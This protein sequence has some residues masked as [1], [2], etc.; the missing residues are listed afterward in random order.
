MN[1]CARGL[2]P[3]R[4][5]DGNAADHTP[6]WMDRAMQF[7]LDQFERFRTGAPLLNIV[8]KKLGY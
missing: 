3:T 7:F 8:D 2:R 1:S 5:S 6:D 4:P